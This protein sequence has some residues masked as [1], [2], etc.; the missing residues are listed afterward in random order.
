M[1]LFEALIKTQPEQA[2]RVP[3]LIIEPGTQWMKR[4]M[5]ENADSSSMRRGIFPPDRQLH[6]VCIYAKKPT[7]ESGK[8]PLNDFA[9]F[10]AG[11]SKIQTLESIGELSVVDAEQ[12]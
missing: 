12:V 11:E 9:F 3:K 6:S 1:R 7:E 4:S 8:N 10:Y 5:P 2:I